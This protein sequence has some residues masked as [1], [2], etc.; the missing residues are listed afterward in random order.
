M[1][2]RYC[3]EA[4]M[5]IDTP[6]YIFFWGH[7][8]TKREMTKACFSQWWKCNFKID[9]VWYNCAEQYMM[10]QKALLFNDV[11]VY[12]KIMRSMDPQEMKELGRTVLGYD[13]IIW[14]LHKYNIVLNANIAK[15]SQNESLRRFLLSTGNAIIVEASPYDKIWGIGMRENNPDVF[16]PRKWKGENLLGFALMETRDKLKNE[17]FDSMTQTENFVEIA[18]NKS[19]VTTTS[20]NANEDFL[21]EYSSLMQ[22]VLKRD[23]ISYSKVKELRAKEFCNTIKIVNDGF[24]YTEDGDKV[25]IN[26]MDEMV[27]YTRFYSNVF[28]V[29]DIVQNQQ[30][31][32]IE[33]I[34]ADCLDEGVRLLKM[35]YNPAILNMA[36]RQN[37][38][39]GVTKGAGAQEETIFRRTNIF[40]SLYQ[41]ASYAGQYGVLKSKYQYPLDKNFG[42]IYTPRVTVFRANEESGY[43]LLS[44][45]YEVAFI[46]VAGMNRPEL[47]RDGMIVDF[48]VEPIKHKI[49]TIFR[50]GLKHGH[51]SLILGA[52]GCG[53]FQNPPRHIARLF[54]EVINEKEFANKYKHIVFAILEDHNSHKNHNVEGNYLPF[55]LEFQQYYAE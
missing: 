14:N 45:P 17:N 26:H 28:S 48:L 52:L 16:Y 6:E 8:S 12:D 46:S 33:V 44:E 7:T 5:Q 13:D 10:A 25:I 20:W 30:Q 36:N 42:G 37:P 11:A 31:T 27:D 53:A 1:K 23:F 2:K 39:G 24:Y 34:D 3:I 19:C 51:D 35:G 38:G 32:I 4:I 55:K 41:F 54:H 29:Q 22:N 15:F 50:I 9:G 43:K 21:Y 40:R 49:R 18:E 47:T